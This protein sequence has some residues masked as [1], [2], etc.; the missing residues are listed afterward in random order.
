MK[1]FVTIEYFG[2][3]ADGYSSKITVDIVRGKSLDTVERRF[4]KSDMEFCKEHDYGG[5]YALAKYHVVNGPFDTKEAAE[6]HAKKCRDEL[7]MV[8]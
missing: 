5:P 2:C 4:L 6:E 7:C 3:D 1:W 8:A